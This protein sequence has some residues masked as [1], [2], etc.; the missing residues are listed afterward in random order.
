MQ[1][2]DRELDFILQEARESYQRRIEDLKHSLK[3]ISENSQDKEV[4]S[5]IEKF[6]PF[7][8][9]PENSETLNY[10]V[11]FKPA[12]G[13][14][15][16]ESKYKI[17]SV[18]SDEM[19]NRSRH[20]NSK[21]ETELEINGELAE[22]VRNL[23]RQINTLEENLE[24]WK[25]SYQEAEATNTDLRVRLKDATLHANKMA[26][27]I[28]KTRDMKNDTAIK[29]I[30][31]MKLHYKK[32]VTIMKEEILSRDS[33]KKVIQNEL[34]MYKQ[35][36]KDLRRVCENQIKEICEEYNRSM[37]AAGIIHN[38]ELTKLKNSYESISETQNNKFVDE[39]NALRSQGKEYE[40]ILRSYKEKYESLMMA[41]ESSDKSASEKEEAFRNIQ[42]NYKKMRSEY[43]SQMRQ[44]QEENSLRQS[45]VSKL[46]EELNKQ[47]NSQL[48]LKL[49]L[50]VQLEGERMKTSNLESKLFRLEAAYSELQSTCQNLHHKSQ[51]LE[52]QL[53]QQPM[54]FQ[55]KYDTEVNRYH[56]KIKTLEAELK[57]LYQAN[58]GQAKE[59]D[60]LKKLC[61]EIEVKQEDDARLLQQRHE[62]NIREIKRIDRYEYLQL[63]DSFEA[64]KVHLKSSEQA[65]EELEARVQDSQNREDEMLRN[66]SRLEKSNKDIGDALIETKTRLNE[67]AAYIH[68]KTTSINKVKEGTRVKMNSLRESFQGILKALREELMEYKAAQQRYI[69]GLLSNIQNTTDSFRRAQIN[70]LQKYNQES[71]LI[72]TDLRKAHEKIEFFERAYQKTQLSLKSLEEENAGLV[73]IIDSRN[74]ERLKNFYDAFLRQLMSQINFLE[75]NVEESYT[76]LNLQTKVIKESFSREI[77]MKS[78]E[79][80]EIANQA[81][82]SIEYYRERLMKIESEKALEVNRSQQELASLEQ[83][84]AQVL[85]DIR[86][87]R[88]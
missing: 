42:M 60:A 35:R 21:L 65:I 6:S 44:M 4:K 69:A 29:E 19:A 52:A 54:D 34:E 71:A 20:L 84:L 22:E 1:N 50:E 47:N 87:H 2:K 30:E 55:K 39:M 13:S 46:S 15:N 81:K 72:S 83:R 88:D 16:E 40:K 78:S 74:P 56:E 85:V 64:T 23:R 77:L 79:S 14:Q 57:S 76:E 73:K 32:K 18:N 66:I 37:R 61:A 59:M 28:F 26:E 58:S 53:H 24:R 11:S 17:R 70:H 3:S 10:S 5:D 75:Q 38:E 7:K 31:N 82:Q 33:E 80:E 67:A 86:D 49:E 43:E 41:K 25:Q 12:S 9:H 36:E 51:V 48:K 68:R 8:S 27:E 63:S 62:E 45:Q